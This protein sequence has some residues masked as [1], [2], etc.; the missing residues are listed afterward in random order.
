MMQQQ[1]E[2]KKKETK[3]QLVQIIEFG[4]KEVSVKEKGQWTDSY[5]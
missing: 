5:Y 1:K 2:K 3:S 4:L